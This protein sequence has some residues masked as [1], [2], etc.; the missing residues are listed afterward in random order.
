MPVLGERSRVVI[1]DAIRRYYRTAHDLV[2]LRRGRRPVQSRRDQDGDVFTR[3][4]RAF[5][6]RQNRGQGQPVRYY[7]K[8][9]SNAGYVGIQIRNSRYPVATMSAV[10]GTTSVPLILQSYDYWESTSA[11]VGPLTLRLTDING[12]TFEDSGVKVAP[13]TE[14]VGQSQFPLCR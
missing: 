2:D 11:G 14:M 8:E 13:Q 5:E 10:G 4:P 6:P 12:Q 9:G 3:N 7:I 1:D